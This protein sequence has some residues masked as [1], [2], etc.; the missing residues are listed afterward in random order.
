MIKSNI[1]GRC[2]LLEKDQYLW[3]GRAA[4]YSGEFFISSLKKPQVGIMKEIVTSINR[5]QRVKIVKVLKDA[6]GSWGEFLRIQ[7]EIQDGPYAGTIADIPVH[8][9]YHPREKWTKEFTLDPNAI[10][11]N[12]DVVVPCS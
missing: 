2:L 4:V 1:Q 7:V 10:E 8:A 6:N 12:E 9:P 5:G 11:F 3:Q